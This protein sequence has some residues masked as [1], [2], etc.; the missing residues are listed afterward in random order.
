MAATPAMKAPG[1]ETRQRISDAARE[2]RRKA[3]FLQR[4]PIVDQGEVYALAKQFF[5]AYLNKPYEYTADELQQ[6]LHRVYLSVTV[7]K[8]VESLIEKISLVEYTDTQYSQAELQLMLEDFIGIVKDMVTEQKRH[9]P[10][11]PRM[12]DWL[13][14]K[15][16]EEKLSVITDFPMLEPNDQ[17]TVEL[18]TLLEK[19]YLALEGNDVKG[20]AR[21]YK[22]LLHKYNHLG[23]TVQRE[24]Y[25]K[26]NEAYEA[27]ARQQE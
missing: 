1:D 20:A 27:I 9:R 25:H 6:E 23:S 24:F 19:I 4:R 17:V 7:R 16:P 10:F 26:V 12:A 21:L 14:R 11:L 5:K 13:F 3:E 15:K 8:R 2:A 22:H 18:N